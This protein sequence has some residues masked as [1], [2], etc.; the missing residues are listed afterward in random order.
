MIKLIFL[1]LINAISIAISFSQKEHIINYTFYDVIDSAHSRQIKTKRVYYSDSTFNDF[2]ILCISDTALICSMKFKISNKS[3][4]IMPNQQW[5]K[6]YD[7]QTTTLFN[8]KFDHLNRE[9]VV[10]SFLVLENDT[11][12]PIILKDTREGG[13]SHLPTFYFHHLYGIVII[14]S[15]TGLYK[16]NDYFNNGIKREVFY[17]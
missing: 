3:W 7:N 15:S 12:Y 1:L 11:L 9:G 16:R 6:F 14:K 13:I 2:R 10:D 4:Y 8:V 5:Q 17:R